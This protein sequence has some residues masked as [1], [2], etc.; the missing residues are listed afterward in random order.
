M[1]DFLQTPRGIAISVAAVILLLGIGPCGWFDAASDTGILGA[2]VRRGP[3][4]ISV[5]QRGNL[6]A[7]NSA[8]ITNSLEGESQILFLIEEGSAVSKGQLVAELDASALI[9]RKIGQEI[10]TEGAKAT[11]INAEQGYRIQESQN[12]SD[13][14]RANQ[15]LEFAKTDLIKYVEGDWPQQLQEADETIEIAKEELAQAKDRLE[16]S[17]KLYEKG[18]LTRTELESDELQYSRS[19]IRLEQNKRSKGLLIKYDNPKELAVLNADVTE[20]IRELERVK[21]QAE[22][23]LVEKQSSMRSAKSKADFEIERLAKL[24]RQIS[25]AKIYA[26]EGGMVVYSQSEGRR[27]S[28]NIIEEGARVYER[29]ELMTIPRTGGMLAEVSLHESVIKKVTAGQKCRIFVDAIPGVT[30]YGEVEF[31]AL[32]PDKNSWW[33][34]PNQRLFRTRVSIFN[35]NV[36]MRPGMSCAVE[37]IVAELADTIYMP[38]QA[39]FTQGNKTICFVDGQAVEVEIG[40]SNEKWI[41]VIS[42]VDPGTVVALNPP[43]GFLAE[44]GG[45]ADAAIVDESDVE[46]DSDAAAEATTAPGV[47]ENAWGANGEDGER[48]EI[49]PE[50]RERFRAM[51][52]QGGDGGQRGGSPHGG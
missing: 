5:V 33:S 43:A 36:D 50:M 37:I 38:L 24:E 31:V 21:L 48:P 30:L 41:E 1:K 10:A 18:F 32:L 2:E 34:N 4:T 44:G 26:P 27:G 7:R 15:N 8:K 46:D 42:G 29:Q 9:D 17:E 39:A 52:G 3:L 13:V 20:A 45:R 23:R 16:W 12:T 19:T 28:E 14:A 47:D 40:Q 22:A 6:S 51:R 49:T 11:S 35:E 25:N